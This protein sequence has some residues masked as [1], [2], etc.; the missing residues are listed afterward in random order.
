MSRTARN[1]QLRRR[2]LE[3]LGQVESIYITYWLPEVGYLV[4]KVR[5]VIVSGLTF[6][7]VFISFRDCSYEDEDV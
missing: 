1:L 3:S 7:P 4:D 6:K 2:P 5:S